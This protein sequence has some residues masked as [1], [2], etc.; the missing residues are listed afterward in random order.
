MKIPSQVF[1]FEKRCPK[2]IFHFNTPQPQTVE[3]ISDLLDADLRAHIQKPPVFGV[4]SGDKL[5]FF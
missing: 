5:T 3:R 1:L 4:E 2:K